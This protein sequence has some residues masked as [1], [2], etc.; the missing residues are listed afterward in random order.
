MDIKTTQNFY[1]DS[2]TVEKNVKN[3]L[4]IKLQPKEV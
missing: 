3:W 2:E 4:T 1:A